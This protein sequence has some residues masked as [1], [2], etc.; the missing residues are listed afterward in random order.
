MHTVAGSSKTSPPKQTDEHNGLRQ[1]QCWSGDRLPMARHRRYNAIT[2][3][4]RSLFGQSAQF[5]C[6][7]IQAGGLPSF[8][9][10]FINIQLEK[11]SPSGRHDP[12][13]CI[14]LVQAPV[15]APFR[16]ALMTLKATLQVENTKKSGRINFVCTQYH[17][18]KNIHNYQQGS[19]FFLFW[20][21]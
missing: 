2:H 13:Q 3:R 15:Q 5:A 12:A 21:F 18:Q 17:G 20:S 19:I 6:I 9:T 4:L 8:C 11:A 1:F 16:Q 7:Q 14:Q 10:L